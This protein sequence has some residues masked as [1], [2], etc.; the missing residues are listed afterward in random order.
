LSMK[1]V[2]Y[3]IGILASF[4]TGICLSGRLTTGINPPAGVG[5]ERPAFLVASWDILHPEQLKPFAD[6]VIPLAQRAGFEMLA[7][8]HAKVLEGSDDG[9]VKEARNV[10]WTS[11]NGTEP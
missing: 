7:D 1:I 4:V 10:P 11:D 6:A 5:K 8:A 9:A 2:I 3:L